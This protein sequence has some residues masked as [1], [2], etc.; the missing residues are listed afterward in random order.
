MSTWRERRSREKGQGRGEE[1]GREENKEKVRKGKRERT[2]RPGDGAR[3]R[4][5]FLFSVN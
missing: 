3:Q 1:Q 4:Y 5:C 2:G